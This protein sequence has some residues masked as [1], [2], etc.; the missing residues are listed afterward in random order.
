MKYSDIIDKVSK[1]LNLPRSIVNKTY[2]AYWLG[3]K[4]FIQDLP[5]KED[6]SEEDFNKLRASFNIPSLGKLNVTWNRLVGCKKRFEIIKKI[7][8][9]N[10]KNIIYDKD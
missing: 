7:R 4:S 6:I 5:L 3:I 1:E 2:K 9:N 8:E 10:K